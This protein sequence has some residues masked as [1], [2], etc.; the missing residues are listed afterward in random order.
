MRDE[1]RKM[2]SY[3]RIWGFLHW[4]ILAS[5]PPK[6][7]LALHLVQCQDGLGWELVA[8]GIKLREITSCVSASKKTHST[9]TLNLH[10]CN[11][12]AEKWLPRNV[13][14]SHS[15]QCEPYQEQVGKSEII[16]RQI[17]FPWSLADDKFEAWAAQI[18]V[19][20]PYSTAQRDQN[21]T[22]PSYILKASSQS[23]QKTP[24]ILYFP[25]KNKA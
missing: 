7:N 9:L 1:R 15:R 20:H 11:Q 19:I 14:T 17:S 10:F 3:F 23:S 8:S 21:I 18:K 6:C 2:V 25:H 5:W 12:A 13:L 22:T 4:I 24:V 16:G